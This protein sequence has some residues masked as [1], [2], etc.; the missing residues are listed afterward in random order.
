MKLSISRSKTYLR[1]VCFQ[2]TYKEM[3]GVIDLEGTSESQKY[4]ELS[5]LLERR[6]K[7]SEYRNKI[8]PV[9]RW[10]QH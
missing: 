9:V 7:N 6:K 10:V 1:E 5:E 3:V 2:T 8:N 4:K